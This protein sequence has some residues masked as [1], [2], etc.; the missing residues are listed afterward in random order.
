MVK[1][2]LITS[3]TKA[4]SS[5]PYKLSTF[6]RVFFTSILKESN[7]LHRNIGTYLSNHKV[8]VPRRP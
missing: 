2:V 6:P 7:G 3:L 5:L 1:I 4:R 8:L